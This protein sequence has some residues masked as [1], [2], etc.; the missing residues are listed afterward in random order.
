MVCPRLEINS[1]ASLQLLT[2]ILGDAMGTVCSNLVILTKK[3]DSSS[4][5]CPLINCQVQKGKI[6]Y[7]L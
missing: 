4:F 2:A 7:I 1:S 5:P 6:I 3:H